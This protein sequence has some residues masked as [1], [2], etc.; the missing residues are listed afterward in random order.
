MPQLQAPNGDICN[1]STKRRHM[2][3]KHQTE[4]HAI[5]APNGDTCNTI[6]KRRHMQYKHQTETHAIQAPNGDTCNTSTKRRH[7]QY[8]HPLCQLA[9]INK[10]RN[11]VRGRVPFE[12]TK[13][14]PFLNHQKAHYLTP[15]DLITSLHP[16]TIG[17]TLQHT[18]K[19]LFFN[20]ALFT[21]SSV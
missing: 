17:F 8:K 3:Y 21:W 6:T 2:Q 20:Y 5:Q 14:S 13:N 11:K 9:D 7:M 15:E 19:K 18:W 16:G 4:T 12:K 1:T 10:Q